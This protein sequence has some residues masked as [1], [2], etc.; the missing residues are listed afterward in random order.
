MDP[1]EEA[2]QKCKTDPI[3]LGK[4]LGYDFQEDVHR[5][6][7]DLLLKFKDGSAI[8]D[9]SEIK[10]RLILWPRGHFKTS[11]MVVFIVQTILNYPDIRVLIMQANQKLGKLW[12]KEI[13]SH[14]L[15]TGSTA[16]AKSMLPLLFPEFCGPV[17][18]NAMEFTV[19]ARQR[20]HLP[21]ATV[22][23][24]STKAANTGQH[25]DVFFPDD[26]VNQKNYRNVELLDE[27][28]N[29]FDLFMP[30]IDPGGYTF[31]T[32]TRYH[33]ADIYGRIIRRNQGE[34]VI[35]VRGASLTGKWPVTS[36]QELLFPVRETSDGRKIGFTTKLLEQFERDNAEQ[37]WAQYFNKI[38]AAKKQIFT[39]QMILGSVRNRVIEKDGKLV[40]NPEFPENSPTVFFVDLAETKGTRSDDSV[41]VAGRQNG[42]SVWITDCVGGTFSTYEL[43]V[44]LIVMTLKH[45]PIRII[46]AKE[47][48]AVH[49]VEYV[50]VLARE[51]GIILPITLQE[52]A[53][54]HKDAKKIRIE[55]LES[56]FRNKQLLMLAG[57]PDFD[58]LL[59][60][61]TQFPKGE[62]DDR[63][64]A[65]AMLVEWFAQGFVEVPRGPKLPWFV[66]H[67]PV[68]EMNESED[69]PM[70][71]GVLME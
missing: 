65:I 15:T 39:E 45:R 17:L 68:T 38:V 5:P 52:K 47:P 30:L 66:T 2:R 25:Y 63:P 67:E 36:D 46:V 28:M 32:G 14:F 20:K 42:N 49:F 59:E 19:P 4:C 56:R 6:L 69:A 9:L 41:V 22:T 7:F 57:I 10:N 61:F 16:N 37:F 44:S 54:R 13:K 27:L 1:R 24:A 12:L 8:R 55:A 26:L 40:P 50:K 29:D 70:L 51:K 71:G 34:W 31:M 35:S 60:E 58:R 3:Y 43:A 53:S 62:H 11:A 48:G 33:H 18:G 21:A 23:V 64:D